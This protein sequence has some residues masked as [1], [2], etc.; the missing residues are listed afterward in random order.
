[1]NLAIRSNGI[2]NYYF[3]MMYDYNEEGITYKYNNIMHEYVSYEAYTTR[4][5]HIYIGT[6]FLA[7]KPHWGL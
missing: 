3:A 5:G 7:D 1:M 6:L 4:A 2:N